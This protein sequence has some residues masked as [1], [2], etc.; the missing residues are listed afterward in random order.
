MSAWT[1]ERIKLATDQNQAF[2]R[3][4][5]MTQSE[6]EKITESLTDA[7]KQVVE[8]AIDRGSTH[9]GRNGTNVQTMRAL[10]RKGLVRKGK[11]RTWETDW[12][13]TDAGRAVGTHLHKLRLD[14]ACRDESTAALK[15]WFE[16][17]GHMSEL[18]RGSIISELATRG[19]QPTADGWTRTHTPVWTIV[20]GVSG[21]YH[22]HLRDAS[23]PN[24]ASLPS[25]CG[26]RVM[27]TRLPLN[28][29][30]VKDHIPSHWCRTCAER[31][32]LPPNHRTK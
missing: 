8:I 20:E 28:S 26:A 15:A 1:G 31:A 19:W 29:W 24:A 7:Q 12:H 6:I 21:T 22:Y 16:E 2:T 17:R 5:L 14:G 10:E 3:T 27:T 23:L 30:G 4:Q 9:S 18:R 25:T 32:E 13:F 11:E